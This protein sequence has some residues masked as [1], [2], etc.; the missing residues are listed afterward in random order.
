[1]GYLEFHSGFVNHW[2]E[3]DDGVYFGEGVMLAHGILPYRSYLDLQPPGFVLL[4]TPFGI[5]GRL[6]GNRMAFELARLFVVVVGIT[7]IALLGRLI[8]RRH[9]TGILTA[10]I[11]LAF[12]SDTLISDHTVLLEP[13]LVFGTLLGFTMIFDDTE[14]ATLSTSRWLVAGVVLGLTTSIKTWEIVPLIVLLVLASMR[15]RRCLATYV[16]GAVGGVALVCAPFFV[17]APGD[18]L[19]DVIVVQVMRSR[20]AQLA[21]VSRLWNLLGAPGTGHT[22]SPA[23]WMPIFFC[24]LAGLSFLLLFLACCGISREAFT[25]LDVCAFACLLLVVIAFLASAEYYPHYGGFLAPI[26]G[27][28][29]SAAAIRLLPMA[30][31]IVKICF[32][33]AILAS[34]ALADRSFIETKY[35]TVP[36]AL[37]DHTFA[38]TA[39]VLSETYSPLILSDRYNLFEKSCPHALDIFGT[40]LADGNGMANLKSDANAPKLQTTWLNW[41]HHVNGVILLSPVPKDLNLGVAART[42][43]QEHF[44][45]IKHIDGLYIYKSK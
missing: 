14:G 30:L 45:L 21:E 10:L 24:I 4:M 20:M 5:L 27:L 40:E 15:D 8:R 1:M 41:L 23:V 9:W 31:P 11:I 18:F 2:T 42:Y 44:S 17:L 34:F 38:S 28:V 33:I 22:V 26:L 7:N 12:Y 32:V 29:L 39:C 36:T 16:V 19:H 37:L 6:I 43:F 3:I 13:F 25:N 35:P